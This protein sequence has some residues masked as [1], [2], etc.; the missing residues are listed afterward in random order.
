MAQHEFLRLFALWMW[1]EVER[2]LK[3]QADYFLKMSGPNEHL[4]YGVEGGLEEKI[5][6]CQY[7]LQP[8]HDGDTRQYIGIITS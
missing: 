3:R 4:R 7:S 1:P 8:C 2:T 5:R 6:R